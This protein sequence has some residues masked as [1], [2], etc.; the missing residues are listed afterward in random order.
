MDNIAYFNNLI[1]LITYKDQREAIGVWR[2]T[3]SQVI[4]SETNLGT[5]YY[6]GLERVEENR[7]IDI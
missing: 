7:G 3:F 1:I 2:T 4:I 6:T 5:Y